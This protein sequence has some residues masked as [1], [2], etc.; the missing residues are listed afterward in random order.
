MG[1]FSIKIVDVD[2]LMDFTYLLKVTIALHTNIMGIRE[3]GAVLLF[4]A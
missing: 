4:C 3:G 2:K 1:C